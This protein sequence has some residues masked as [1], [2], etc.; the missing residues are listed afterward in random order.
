MARRPDEVDDAPTGGVP[1]V[2]WAVRIPKA[3][4]VMTIREQLR[5]HGRTSVPDV[6]CETGADPEQIVEIMMDMDRDGEGRLVR[7]AN[8]PFMFV[9]R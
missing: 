6:L 8:R 7:R 4:V 9:R 2:D 3:L 5:R 1:G